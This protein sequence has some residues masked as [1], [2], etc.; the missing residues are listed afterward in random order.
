MDLKR[1]SRSLK[2]IAWAI[3]RASASRLDIFDPL[4][5]FHYGIN[6]IRLHTL[7]LPCDCI[8]VYPLM[9]YFFICRWHNAVYIPP[10]TYIVSLS[11][12]PLRL[13]RVPKYE[14]PFCGPYIVYPYLALHSE[15]NYIQMLWNCRVIAFLLWYIHRFACAIS[16]GAFISEPRV[17]APL[18]LL[19]IT[20]YRRR[21][22]YRCL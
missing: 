10:R 12:P 14:P 17:L 9:I 8:H 20:T 4:L 3:I 7:P 15:L 13:K 18:Y 2:S 19:K 22:R 1:G 11:S 6:L 5:P 16:E 21:D